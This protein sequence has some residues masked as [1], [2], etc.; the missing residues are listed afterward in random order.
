VSLA[1]ARDKAKTILAKRQLGLD[2]QLTPFFGA[3][4]EQYLASRAGKVAQSTAR[5]DRL[6]KRF[7]SLDRKRI[8]DISPDAV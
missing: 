7:S 6:L 4:R 8:A 3:A 1:Q 5:H 2:Q